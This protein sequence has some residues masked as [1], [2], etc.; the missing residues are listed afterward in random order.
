VIALVFGVVAWIVVAGRTHAEA[1]FG[2]S[3][4]FEEIARLASDVEREM[5]RLADAAQS[6]AASACQV[7]ATMQDVAE[8]ALCSA[9]GAEQVVAA[10]GELAKIAHALEGAVQ[11]FQIV[12]V[13]EDRAA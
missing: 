5:G 11:R 7:S 3:S 13:A 8:S 10:S 1:V 4:R 2:L 6:E 9:Q 12:D